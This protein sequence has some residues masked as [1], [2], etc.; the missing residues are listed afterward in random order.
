MKETE[1]KLKRVIRNDEIIRER[2]R[3]RYDHQP[4]KSKISRFAWV[5]CQISLSVSLS[6]RVRAYLLNM[7]SSCAGMNLHKTQPLYAS[8]LKLTISL[9]DYISLCFFNS[10]E[11]YHLNFLY[12][13][14]QEYIRMNLSL[15]VLV[16]DTY[17]IKSIKLGV[18]S[19]SN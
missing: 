6:G 1:L 12:I 16:C 10:W 9:K 19:D 5:M 14:D 7:F 3:E 2:E 15:H 8:Q 4:K 13:L 17:Y 18:E 11:M